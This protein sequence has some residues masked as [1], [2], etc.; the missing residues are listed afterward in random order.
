MLIM[1]I[2]RE[3]FDTTSNYGQLTVYVIP[4]RNKEDLAS[5]KTKLLLTST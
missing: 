4:G 5:G 2:L 1:K 3:E